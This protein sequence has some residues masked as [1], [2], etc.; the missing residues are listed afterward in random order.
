MP[1]RWGIEIYPK[2]KPNEYIMLMYLSP[3]PIQPKHQIYLAKLIP[4]SRSILTSPNF[5]M[6]FISAYVKYFLQFKKLS[7]LKV[8]LTNL[9]TEKVNMWRSQTYKLYLGSEDWKLTYIKFRKTF[10]LFLYILKKNPNC[11]ERETK[12][13]NKQMGLHQTKKCLHSKGNHQQNEKTAHWMG[14]HICRWYIW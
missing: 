2:S 6:L 8:K 7:V 1:G 10:I 4:T 14:D 9:K 13:K 12:E 11:E 3:I 5:K